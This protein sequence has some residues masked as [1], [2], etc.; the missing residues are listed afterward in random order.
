MISYSL[1]GRY[2]K[3]SRERLRIENP[4]PMQGQFVMN[5]NFRGESVCEVGES[6]SSKPTDDAEVRAEFSSRKGDFIHRHHN[7][8]RV[9][10]QVPIEETFFITVLI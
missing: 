3:I 8:P 4:A 9:Q 1:C 6:Q 5:E 2:S 10:L 7:D